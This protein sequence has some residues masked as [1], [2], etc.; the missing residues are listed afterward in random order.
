M[1]EIIEEIVAL[2]Q[3]TETSEGWMRTVEIQQ[4]LGLTTDKIRKF[5]RE[6]DE[7]GR[8]ECKFVTVRRIS[9]QDTRVPAYRV[10]PD[11]TKN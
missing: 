5:L 9:G 3:R 7:Q 2:M 11:D 8:L 10:K 6:L 4:A 1:A